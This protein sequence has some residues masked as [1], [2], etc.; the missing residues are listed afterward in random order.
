MKRR[1][2]DAGY[3]ARIADAASYLDAGS[4]ERGDDVAALLEDCD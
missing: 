3:Y 4:C 2:G 1:S